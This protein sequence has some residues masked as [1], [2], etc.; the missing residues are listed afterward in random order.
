LREYKSAKSAHADCLDRLRQRMGI[1]SAAE[2]D[3]LKHEAERAK[4]RM[5]RGR[6][7]LNEHIAEH[8]CTNGEDAMHAG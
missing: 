2:Y 7:A 5:D 8:G 6:A 3:A 1:C 4:A